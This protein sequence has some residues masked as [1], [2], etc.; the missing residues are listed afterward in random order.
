MAVAAIF[1][2]EKDLNLAKEITK[3]PSNYTGELIAIKH[4]IKNL[5]AEEDLQTAHIYSDSLTVLRMLAYEAAITSYKFVS[6]EKKR[7][8]NEHN[9]KEK[10][11]LYNYLARK[12]YNT[13]KYGNRLQV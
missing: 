10:N 4:V 6:N 3:F 5:N 11:K 13:L 8:Q 1:H 12:R 7:K 9:L 2:K